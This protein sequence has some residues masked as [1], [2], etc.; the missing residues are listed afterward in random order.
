MSADLGNQR[1]LKVQHLQGMEDPR[2]E[3]I[4]S[5]VFWKLMAQETGDPVQER[6]DRGITQNDGS[7]THFNTISAASLEWRQSDWYQ[8]RS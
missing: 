1:K 7:E 8:D 4:L 3:Q 5:V 2:T 6:E